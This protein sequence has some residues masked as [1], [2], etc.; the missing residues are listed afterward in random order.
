M[1]STGTVPRIILAGPAAA[2]AP[3]ARIL[4]AR[5]LAPVGTLGRTPGEGAEAAAHRP[6]R[7]ADL[8][9]PE[10]LRDAEI[11]IL[12]EGAAWEKRALG[13]I[14][15]LLPRLAPEA[16][17]IASGTG[18]SR[19]AMRFFESSRLDPRRVIATG[20]LGAQILLEGSLAIHASVSRAQ[21]SLLV[22]GDEH[23]RVLPL[24]RFVRVA[25]IPVRSLLSTGQTAPLLEAIAPAAERATAEQAAV[26]LLVDAVHRDRRRVLCCASLSPGGSG[27]PES[28]LTLPALIGAGGVV[29]RLPLSLTLEER[30]FL[31]KDRDSQ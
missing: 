9:T 18:S 29:G 16:V 24:A 28:F 14:A 20:A 4:I 26:A 22:M 5:G 12:A 7:T 30:V 25:G 17:V 2:T 31:N 6:D 13:E 10:S 21:V 8:R 15:A 19:A 1:S 23:G 27:L 11:V 3:L